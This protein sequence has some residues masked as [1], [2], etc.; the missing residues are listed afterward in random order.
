MT[1]DFERDPLPGRPRILFVGFPYSSHTH[2]WIDLVREQFN[3]RLFGMP[4]G[5]PPDGW[6]VRTYVTQS[7]P[8]RFDPATRRKLYLCDKFG[9]AV[10]NT[11]S[12]ALHGVDAPR[13]HL[14]RIIRGWKPHVVH[15][16]GL[17]ES[18][19]FYMDVRERFGLAGLHAWVLQLWGGSDVALARFDPHKAPRLASAMAEADAVLTDTPANKDIALSLGIAQDKAAAFHVLPGAGGVDA[20]GLRA[21]WQGPVAQRRDICWPKAYECPWSKALP[22]FEA[23]KMLGSRLEGHTIHMLAADDETRAWHNALPADVRLRCPLSGR[24][25]HTDALALLGASRIMLAPSLVDGMPN[26]LYEAMALG[27]APVVSP[28]DEIARLVNDKRNALFAR[29]LYPEE[30]AGAMI[31]LLE[32]DML[33]T[34]IVEQNLKLV[35]DLADRTT[36]RTKAVELY[37]GLHSW[38]A[39][40]RPPFP[41][42]TVRHPNPARKADRCA[43]R[44][45]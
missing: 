6:P 10:Q 33:A 22:V 19:Y 1:G 37:E 27:A 13:L 2:G 24:I 29:N 11:V 20:A 32:D 23:V 39:V 17:D 18:G 38:S 7:T 45:S 14:A 8:R 15:T 4:R 3:V 12:R 44:S 40:A 36:V 35:N 43:R 41:E 34:A 31:R 16:L 42:R 9:R 25:P 28:L 26:S 21:Y 5:F 30:I